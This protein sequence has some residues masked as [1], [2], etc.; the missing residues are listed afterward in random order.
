MGTN[1][2]SSTIL[3][4]TYS[5]WLGQ[6]QITIVMPETGQALEQKAEVIVLLLKRGLLTHAGKLALT[7]KG[8]MIEVGKGG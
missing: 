8:L 3:N 6:M 2:L 1:R 5:L 7:S 4:T